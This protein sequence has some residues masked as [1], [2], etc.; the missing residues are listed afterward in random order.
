M[1]QFPPKDISTSSRREAGDD[2]K[3]PELVFVKADLL[4]KAN[5]NK[6]TPPRFIIFIESFVSSLCGKAVENYPALHFIIHLQRLKAVK[7]E[8]MEQLQKQLDQFTDSLDKTTFR[9]LQKKTFDCSSKCCDDTKQ[10]HETF[11]R[12]I[13]NCAVTMQ[14]KETV[15]NNE[16]QIFQQKVQ[17]CAQTCNDKAQSFLES[18]GIGGM[19]KAQRKAMECID[20]CARDYGK[21]LKQIQRRVVG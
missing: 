2:A 17:R 21:E 14:E 11:Q 6:N 3:L 18:D 13:Q 1:K 19:D 5:R 20:E 4:D 9:P 8:D 12:C 10:S 15:V 16:L 7:E